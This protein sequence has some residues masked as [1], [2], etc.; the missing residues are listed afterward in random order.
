LPTCCGPP[1]PKGL[2]H[3]FLQSIGGGGE[4]GGKGVALV[5]LLA[6]ASSIVMSVGRLV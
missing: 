4:G 1:F 6:H 2:L 3:V 5:V